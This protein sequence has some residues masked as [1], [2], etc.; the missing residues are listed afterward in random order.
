MAK[1]FNLARMTT[2]TTGTGTITLGAAVAGYLSFA[3]AGVAN[4]DVVDY[5]IKDGNNSE[6]G[7]GTYAAA[8]RT[9]TRSVSAST[10]GNAAINLSGTAEVFITARA[11]TLLT[12]IKRQV[13]TSSAT[14]TPLPG[15]VFC[16]IEAIGAGGGGGGAFS[17]SATQAY[18]GGGGGAGSYSRKYAT[19]ADIGSSQTVT[20]G[21]GG[22]GGNQ[23]NNGAVGGDTSVGSLCIGKGGGSGQYGSIGQFPY[24]APGGGLGTG[25]LTSVGAPG[26]PG[27]YCQI[28]TLTVASGTGGASL[29]GSGGRGVFSN[30]SV[31]NGNAAN[32]YG[33][34]GSGALN[35]SVANSGAQGGPGSNGVAIIT[36]FCNGSG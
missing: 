35:H 6:I 33:S 24:G 7:T 22:A 10:N 11:E 12:S 20:I 16:I 14:Y 21:V 26:T 3:Q 25:D 34:G 23:Q 1:L 31:I 4:G 15:M 19:A 27:A 9:L 30:S 28:N 13:F 36:E 2:A 5:A 8:G 18:A 32:G 17:A 29:F